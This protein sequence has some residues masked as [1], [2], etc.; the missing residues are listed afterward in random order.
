MTPHDTPATGAPAAGL[1]FGLS[2]VC[3]VFNTRPGLLRQAV[4]SVLA[5]DCAGGEV[6]ILLV[7]DASTSAATRESLAALE[8]RHPAAVR[9]IRLDRNGGPARARNAGLDAASHPW[10]GFIDADDLWPA[11]KLQDAGRIAREFPDTGWIAG[12][13]A[14]LDAADQ[15]EPSVA[16]TRKCTVASSGEWSQRIDSPTLTRTLANDWMHLGTSLVRKSLLQSAGG[17]DERLT[18]GEDWLLFLKLA[19]LTPVDYARRETYILRRQEGSMMRSA[20]RM[21]RRFSRSSEIAARDPALRGVRREI[22][23]FRYK[24]YKDLAMNNFV[25]GHYPRAW[26][27]A[28]RAL[29]VSP[30]EFREYAFF[31]GLFAKRKNTDI[32]ALLFQYSK[33]EQVRLDAVP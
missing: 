28:T 30:D 8:A 13:F 25:N 17:F 16:L 15:L 11:H 32:G 27:F 2:V 9:V 33:T 3:P 21:T 5:Q 12:N 4:E 6:E 18:Y 19:T 24:V 14:V 31:L 7:D 22:R 10:I 26:Y 20:A 1:P 23:W 29:A